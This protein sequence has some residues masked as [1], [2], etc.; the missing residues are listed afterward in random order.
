MLLSTYDRSSLPR[1]SNS[2]ARVCTH[3]H[4]KVITQMNLHTRNERV[5]Y[6]AA[7]MSLL[8]QWNNWLGIIPSYVNHH[9]LLPFPRPQLFLRI[10]RGVRQR[11]RRRSEQKGMHSFSIKTITD[12]SLRMH[13]FLQLPGCKA[14]CVPCT[15]QIEC[16]RTYIRRY[17]VIS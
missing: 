5:Y 15:F 11:G 10:V 4:K 16:T 12:S 13:V 1:Y 6:L 8:L 2:Q 3:L 7:L 17:A 14:G 9:L